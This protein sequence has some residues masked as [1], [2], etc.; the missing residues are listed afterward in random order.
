M[1]TSVNS[2]LLPETFNWMISVVDATNRPNPNDITI[3]IQYLDQLNGLKIRYIA[4]EVRRP[5]IKNKPK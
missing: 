4:K 5:L 2:P 1:S 3:N